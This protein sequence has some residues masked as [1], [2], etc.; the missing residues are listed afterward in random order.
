MT[1]PPRVRSRAKAVQREIRA[2][3]DAT[4]FCDDCGA[5][6]GGTEC[7]CRGPITQPPPGGR[8]GDRVMWPAYACT[9]TDSALY[10]RALQ[11]ACAEGRVRPVLQ[12]CCGGFKKDT[13]VGMWAL[14]DYDFCYTR[15]P[16]HRGDRPHAIGCLCG[17]CPSTMRQ[18]ADHSFGDGG[19]DAKGAARCS[20]CGLELGEEFN[21]T[22]PES[23]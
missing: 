7:M 19:W 9:R 12:A 15:C 1:S 4:T 16:R 3:L 2:M 13:A 21:L 22:F 14:P 20:A 11:R 6:V 10:M 8:W 23:P 17:A 18:C 5:E